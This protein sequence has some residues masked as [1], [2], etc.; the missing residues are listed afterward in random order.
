MFIR[1][2]P[3]QQMGLAFAIEACAQETARECPRLPVIARQVALVAL[4]SSFIRL[5]R[6]MIS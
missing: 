2:E 5:K 4:L 6:Q 3:N 1:L